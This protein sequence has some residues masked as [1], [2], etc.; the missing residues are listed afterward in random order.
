MDQFQFELVVHKTKIPLHAN[1]INDN[2]NSD[3]EESECV[4]DIT[5]K[6]IR[7]TVEENEDLKRQNIL[8]EQQL[9]EKERRIK[10]LERLLLT[11][12]KSQF[13]WTNGRKSFSVN[14]ATQTERMH[15]RTSSLDRNYALN[16]INNNL[17]SRSLKVDE[18]KRSPSMKM[19]PPTSR[20]TSSANLANLR[21]KL[22]SVKNGS[23]SSSTSYLPSPV[24]PRRR[25]LLN[26]SDQD[27]L[28]TSNSLGSSNYTS[29]TNSTS[30][31]LSPR[32]VRSKSSNEGC[33]TMVESNRH[34]W[35]YTQ[36]S[37]KFHNR[38]S[39]YHLCKYY[40]DSEGTLSI[41]LCDTL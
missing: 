25:F 4:K 28:K 35:L 6:A 14:T 18:T 37:F 34:G 16:N 2:E 27:K 26:G 30:Y 9:E 24:T 39:N 17:R 10:A 11:E 41:P 38:P 8:L 31:L 21:E 13:S 36:S 22:H 7:Q 23:S 1:I 15:S 32:P 40:S 12:E 29:S 33:Q 5:N 19:L 20:S 3:E